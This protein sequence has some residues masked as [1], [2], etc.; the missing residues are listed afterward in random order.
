MVQSR[1]AQHDGSMGAF[2]PAS[3]AAD[4]ASWIHSSGVF[5]CNGPDRTD[6]L[7]Y[8]AAKAPLCIGN[9]NVER[10]SWPLLDLTDTPA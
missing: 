5:D 1:G 3:P 9:G 4:A 8:A 6:G 10:D 2:V 7:A